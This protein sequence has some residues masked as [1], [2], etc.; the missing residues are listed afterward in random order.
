MPPALS[1]A[2]D[3]IAVAAVRRME[4]QTRSGQA[5]K[6]L[7]PE[8]ARPARDDLGKADSGNRR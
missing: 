5:L 2:R 1:K 6:N 3:R 8:D 7:D 4:D